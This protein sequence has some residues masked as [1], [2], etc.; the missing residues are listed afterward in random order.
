MGLCAGRTGISNLYLGIFWTGSTGQG[1]A[2]FKSYIKENY[3]TGSSICAFWNTRQILYILI[4]LVILQ[5]ENLCIF[6]LSKPIINLLLTYLQAGKKQKPFASEA[7]GQ[8]VHNLWKKCKIFNLLFI[9]F[10]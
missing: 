8:T 6:I 4:F 5:Y 3:T 1:V 9:Y 7:E 10:K 2:S